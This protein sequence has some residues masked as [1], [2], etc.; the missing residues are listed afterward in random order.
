[1][2]WAFPSVQKNSNDL[3]EVAGADLFSPGTEYQAKLAKC[4]RPPNENAECGTQRTIFSGLSLVI[5][6]MNLVD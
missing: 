1:M 6:W 5:S 3:P 4:G 2:R